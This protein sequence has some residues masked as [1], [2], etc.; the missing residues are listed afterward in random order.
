M[1][2]QQTAMTTQ[3]IAD[4]LVTICRSG[5]WD[6]AQRELYAEGAVSLE[7]YATP[8]FEQETRGLAAILEKGKKFDSMVDAMH[9]IKV[10]DPLVADNSFACVLDM[11]VTM[12]EGGR[13]H[14]KELCIYQVKDGKIIEER[15][16]V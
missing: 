4:R 1:T 11:D 15:F 7:P 5:E 6:K 13:M 14:M 3:Q 10:S 2:T 8:A 9:S 16:L 12:K